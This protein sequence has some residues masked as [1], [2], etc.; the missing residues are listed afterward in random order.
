MSKRFFF[1]CALAIFLSAF[2]RAAPAEETASQWIW[3][4]EAAPPR[5]EV[6]CF[7][8]AF[9]LGRVPPRATLTITCDSQY[10]VYVNGKLAGAGNEWQVPG[11]F[12]IAPMLLR[13][14][15]AI[16]VKAQKDSPGAPGL[17]I[18]LDGGGDFHLVSDRNWTW[19]TIEVGGWMLADFAA[20]GWKLSKEIGPSTAAPWSLKGW[21]KNLAKTDEAPDGKGNFVNG[22]RVP[23]GFI[24]EHYA[25]ENDTSSVLCMTFNGRGQLLTGAAGN[26]P[27][28][29]RILDDTNGVCTGHRTFYGGL[30][31][32]GMCA[33]GTNIY[34]IG[35]GKLYLLEDKAGQGHA[36]VQEAL[37]PEMLGSMTEH[38][39]HAI[40]LGPDG[41]FYIMLGNDSSFKM[42]NFSEPTS[43]I[44][45]EHLY[46]GNLLPLQSSNFMDGKG[47]PGGRLIRT[48]LKGKTWELIAHGI[49]NDYD[50]AFASS[51]EIFGFDS[52]ME[53]DIGLPW[54]RPVRTIHIPFGANFGWRYGSGKWKNHTP[55]GTPPMGEV[56]RG[57]PTGVEV[58][59]HVAFPEE[60]RE[61]VFLCD[62]SRAR[63]LVMKPKRDGATW[64][65][66]PTEFLAV[67]GINFPVTDACVGPDGAL[68]FGYGGRG[69]KG[70][71]VRVRYVG[72][73]AM[74]TVFGPS[75]LKG[76]GGPLALALNTPQY[77]SA[78]GRASIA[79]AK[80][81]AA[82][83]W[84]WQLA[85][86]A[87]DPAR[88]DALRGRALDLLGMDG[89]II[90]PVLLT[91]LA[92]DRSAFMRAQAAQRISLNGD[93]T[94]IAALKSMLSDPDPWV[95]RRACEGLMR[96]PDPAATDKLVALLGHDDRFVRYAASTALLRLPTDSWSEKILT[97][98]TPLARAE[99]LLTWAQSF[100]SMSYESHK[101]APHFEKLLGLC[102][103]ML[104]AKLT[105][106]ETLIALRAASL[107]LLAR[108]DKAAV[109]PELRDR[110]LAPCALLLT[111][112]DRR[113]AMDAAELLGFIADGRAVPLLVA[114]LKNDLLERDERIHYAY[115]VA[116]ISE[117]WTPQ[118]AA[119]V[120]EF[121]AAPGPGENGLSFASNLTLSATRLGKNLSPGQRAA[122]FNLLSPGAKSFATSIQGFN[123]LSAANVADEYAKVKDI[124]AR[125]QLLGKIAAAG[126]E[127]AFHTLEKLV[128][129]TSPVY[130]TL[131]TLL[132]RF[133]H[134]EAKKYAVA[135]LTSSSRG[136]AGEALARVIQLYKED[137]EDQNV[138]FGLVAC[139]ARSN[140]SRA[141]ALEQLKKWP[142]DDKAVNDLPAN[143]EDQ[144][145]FWE[146]VYKKNYKNDKRQFP[147]FSG[148]GYQDPAKFK[149]L[150]AFIKSN[151]GNAD[152]G[153]EL[154]KSTGRCVNCHAFKG[155]PESNSV[156]S[157]PT[158][159]SASI[160]EKFSTT[161]ST[162]RRWWTPAT[163]RSS[164]RHQR[165]PAHQRFRVGGDGRQRE[166][167]QQRRD[168]GDG[169]EVGDQREKDHGQI[170]HAGRPGRR[171]DTRANPRPARVPR[172]R[173]EMNSELFR[174]GPRVNSHSKP[175]SMLSKPSG[176]SSTSGSF[177]IARTASRGPKLG[178]IGAFDSLPPST[179]TCVRPCSSTQ[180]T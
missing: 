115:A 178:G 5:A 143:P 37:C 119:D 113:V 68:Y 46:W 140:E 165:R 167:H 180:R 131:L 3:T 135:G 33:I 145:A 7:R 52:D 11:V 16:A 81:I 86:L 71:I 31:C 85:G 9:V 114:K 88:S 105:P 157:S 75:E 155:D 6:R 73:K 174:V 100:Q 69:A 45:Q 172:I 17:L 163:S 28:E 30:H 150:E 74:R 27:T 127:E 152:A 107:T 177:S 26:G 79:R 67:K 42:S 175:D 48:D 103:D 101:I 147:D 65:G 109:T 60:Y 38:G 87:R 108:V 18:D 91:D 61:A 142:I 122:A 160:S 50:F 102:A 154:F 156:P 77:M 63:V 40:V 83:D 22:F 148:D 66:E 159:P 133:N 138:Y 84:N 57:S 47:P 23:E 129:E 116:N 173:E 134:V 13:G 179:L 151:P 70:G 97:L 94:A 106:E 76:I 32:Q 29:I 36:E 90:D 126:N 137:P 164:L 4:A 78:F 51:G 49:R 139:A 169:E 111:H 125:K 34:A 39:P 110:M 170:D 118:S 168:H 1:P 64:T 53:Y 123:D 128:D 162:R 146:Q 117:G 35:N 171:T 112:D 59:N 44:R 132:M 104:A 144:I 10:E 62:W 54:Y 43:P 124:E 55:D 149:K 141:T 25:T 93:T 130:D 136:L 166:H 99:G 72:N 82:A 96:F 21:P 153:K 19:Y 92:K 15:N 158:S 58:Y 120:L 24:A 56:G 121:L 80:L 89:E 20:P 14:S 8:R 2:F 12:N 161:S 176:I 95:L 98:P 41:H